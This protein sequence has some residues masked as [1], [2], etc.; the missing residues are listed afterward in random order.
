MVAAAGDSQSISLR[1]GWEE[2]SRKLKKTQESSRKL[3]KAVRERERE[4]EIEREREGR[5]ET[6]R[7]LVP[8]RTVVFL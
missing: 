6:E 2:S 3:K 4:G 7:I 5:R 1:L 8:P